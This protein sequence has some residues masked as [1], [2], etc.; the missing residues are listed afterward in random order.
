MLGAALVGEVIEHLLVIFH[1]GGANG[2]SVFTGVIQEAMG[3]YA[4]TAPP[5]L[6]MAKRNEQHPTEL[7]DLFGKRLVVISETNDGQKL[8]EGLVKMLTGGERIR[9]RHMRQDHWEF[10]PSHLPVLVTNHKPRVIGTDYAIWRRLRL[11]PF[12]VTIPE[13]RQDK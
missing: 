6:L 8:D 13:A 11:V 4:M 1:G 2:K 9:A 12:G 10:R 3:D 7:A 5:G